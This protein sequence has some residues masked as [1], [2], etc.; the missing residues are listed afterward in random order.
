MR[1]VPRVSP[2]TATLIPYPSL[3]RACRFGARPGH[4]D[5]GPGR[6]G[7]E[8]A[9]A[10]DRHRRADRAGARHHRREHAGGGRPA[11]RRPRQHRVRGG[12]GVIVRTLDQIVGSDRDVH[13][14]TWSSRRLVLADDGVGFSLHDTVIHAGTETTM[15][16]RNHIEAVHCISSE[17]TLEDTATGETPEIGRA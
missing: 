17:G 7:R 6:R 14:D 13:A 5:G 12:P 3:F 16:Y 10:A 15:W 11:R 4:R 8:D 2:L 1:C 9:A